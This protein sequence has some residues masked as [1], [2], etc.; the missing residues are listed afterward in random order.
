MATKQ[1]NWNDLDYDRSAASGYMVIGRSSTGNNRTA[2]ATF[3]ALNIDGNII[4]VKLYYEWDNTAG[5]EGFKGKFTHRASIGSNQVTY[6]VDNTS[7]SG[8]IN[9]PAGW[10]NTSSFVVDLRAHTT[11]TSTTK[12]YKQGVYIIVTYETGDNIV[13]ATIKGSFNKKVTFIKTAPVK[14][15]INKNVLSIKAAATKGAIN[16]AVP[17]NGLLGDINNDGIIDISDYTRISLY[18]QGLITLTAEE[19]ARAD[20]NQDG[21]VNETD[22]NIIRNITLS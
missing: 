3:P 16:K 22:K 6:T 8:S 5:G 19:L 12:S 13:T 1:V 9:L 20:I 17:Y 14:G 11:A 2:Q 10:S 7:G 15:S 21:I 4:S 18:L